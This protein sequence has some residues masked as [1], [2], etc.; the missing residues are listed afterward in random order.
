MYDRCKANAIP[1]RQTGK[2][3][4]A[5]KDQL[6][7]INGL[8]N[9]SQQLTQPGGPFETTQHGPAL[10]TTLLSGAE[11]RELEADLSK[12]IEGAL[13]VPVTGILDSHSFM[14]S[15]ERDV[16]ESGA[17]QISY[18]TRT[19]RV[20]PYQRA[21]RPANIPDLEPQ[22]TGWVVQTVTGDA[23]EGDAILAKVVI[24][25][26]GLSSTLILNSL[27]PQEKRI[28]MFYAKGSY[29]KY[30]G[31]G[32]SNV[33]HLIYPCP[34]T[35]PNAHAFQSLGTHLTLDL[36]GRVRFGPDIQWISAPD[37]LGSDPEEDADFWAK[38][39]VPDDARLP[40]MHKAITT[41]LPSVTLEGLQPDYCGMRP[42]L[43][44]PSGGFQDFVFRV[45]HPNQDGIVGDDFSPMISL[46]GIESPGLTAS[47]GVA[48]WVVDGIM[49]RG[50]KPEVW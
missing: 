30:S 45:D 44:P 48:E 31:P 41:Y 42:K 5:R 6:P 24:N 1:Y 9:K 22:T 26:S 50:G 7:Y 35:G 46:L 10:K 28:P 33:K 49:K 4:V 32:V 11:A 18:A 40:E 16:L 23:T 39:L 17:G 14:E 15:L 8:H 2:L 34:E 12:E 21:K 19:V 37:T 27:L 38:H 47:L 20:D 29:A 36:D 13:W 3:V 43:V 25:A